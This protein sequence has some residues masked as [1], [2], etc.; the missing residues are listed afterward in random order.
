LVALK[1]KRGE[2]IFIGID[3]TNAIFLN[4]NAT[5]KEQIL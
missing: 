2:N 3:E 4:K 1:H 5:K